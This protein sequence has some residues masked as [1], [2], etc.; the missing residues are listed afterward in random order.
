ML[1]SSTFLPLLLATLLLPLLPPSTASTLPSRARPLICYNDNKTPAGTPFSPRSL[2]SDLSPRSPS[3]IPIPCIW[4]AP[5]T[6]TYIQINSLL[7][8]APSAVALGEAQMQLLSNALNIISKVLEERGDGLVPAGVFDL[9]QF[10]FRYYC[11]NANNHQQT[12]GVLQ[13]AVAA[14][15][16]F[17]VRNEAWGTVT[18][19][20]WDGIWA[21]AEGVFEP[22]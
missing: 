2:T 12:W 8:L 18:F 21:V 10:G 6:R 4:C 14:L 22:A 3:Q 7:P 11:R 1:S 16:S 17:Y 9:S 15:L 20:V 5:K 13:A 19:W